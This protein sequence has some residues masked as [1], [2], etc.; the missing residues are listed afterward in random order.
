MRVDASFPV[1]LCVPVTL[2]QKDITILYWPFF[3]RST[4]RVN[5]VPTLNFFLLFIHSMSKKILP[6]SSI[7]GLA[8]LF[9]T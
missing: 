9:F 7:R 4:G 3:H 6:D 2:S 5:G 1:E 8:Q